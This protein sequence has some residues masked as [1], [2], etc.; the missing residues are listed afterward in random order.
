[1]FEHHYDI[2][3]AL[4][5]IWIAFTW[6]TFVGIFISSTIVVFSRLQIFPFYVC[7][8]Y[9]GKIKLF[10]NQKNSN[11]N[12]A[13][14]ATNWAEQFF[15]I[16]DMILCVDNINNWIW[17]SIKNSIIISSPSFWGRF[18]QEWAV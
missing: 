11:L 15:V 2:W 13:K 12:L 5:D 4:N 18:E 17:Y 7:Y 10:K 1:M 8:V 6:N 14:Q 9:V 16:L 3:T